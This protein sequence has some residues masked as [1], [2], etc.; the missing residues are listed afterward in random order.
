MGEALEILAAQ[1]CSKQQAAEAIGVSVPTID[2]YVL[3]NKLI[4]Y[5]LADGNR[6]IV[7]ISR[8]SVRELLTNRP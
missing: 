6:R 2:N 8:D 5:R 7:L 3:R 4:A 1:T